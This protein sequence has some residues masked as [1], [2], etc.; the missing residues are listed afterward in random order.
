[1]MLTVVPKKLFLS[2]NR[3][4]RQH[5]VVLALILEKLGVVDRSYISFAKQSDE[6][7]AQTFEEDIRSMKQNVVNVYGVQFNQIFRKVQ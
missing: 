2:W 7:S 3:R 6:N 1:M 4:F 5:R